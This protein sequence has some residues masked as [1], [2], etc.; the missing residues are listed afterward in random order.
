MSL[1]EVGGPGEE[2]CHRVSRTYCNLS[3][4][5][6]EAKPSRMVLA[7]TPHRTLAGSV[8]SIVALSPTMV[9]TTSFPLTFYNSKPATAATCDRI[10]CGSLSSMWIT[11]LITPAVYPGMSLSV[12]CQKRGVRK[13]P[14]PVVEHLSSPPIFDQVVRILAR[15]QIRRRHLVP[16]RRPNKFS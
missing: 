13:L 8:G 11:T 14:K 15:Q 2:W 6:V 1:S 9:H 7:P 5:H 10:N 16:L 4:A 3:P 12:F